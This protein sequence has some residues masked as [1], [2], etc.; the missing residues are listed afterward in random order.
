MD[1]WM[2]VVAAAV[3]AVAPSILFVGLWRG[4][5]RLRDDD[6]VERV[7]GEWGETEPYVGPS[8]VPRSLVPEGRPDPDV[9]AGADFAPCDE[10]GAPNARAATYCHECLSQLPDG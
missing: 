5:M 10:C 8:I 1:V 4:L 7:S 9:S 2:R 3:L 6:L